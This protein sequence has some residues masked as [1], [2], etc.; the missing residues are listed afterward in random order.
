MP[1][2]AVARAVGRGPVEDLAEDAAER[3]QRLREAVARLLQQ[4]ARV[5]P[6]RGGGQRERLCSFLTRVRGR[7]GGE[8]PRRRKSDR[9]W[10]GAPAWCDGKVRLQ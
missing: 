9:A 1:T 10:C 2:A 4:P 3:G 5:L 7:R 8:E 6:E